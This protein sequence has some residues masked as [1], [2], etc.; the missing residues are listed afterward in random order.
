MQEILKAVQALSEKEC[1]ECLEERGPLV[2]F[3][4]AYGVIAEELEETEEALKAT[5]ED[6]QD[7]WAE[8]RA[9]NDIYALANLDEMKNSA[10]E[11]AAEAI[12][13]AA[14]CMKAYYCLEGESE[15]RIT[16]SKIEREDEE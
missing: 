5:R 8:A 7:F 12:Q 3:H 6:F 13:V 2:D 11:T 1:E 10:W 16:F 4:H 9:N 14:M 15:L